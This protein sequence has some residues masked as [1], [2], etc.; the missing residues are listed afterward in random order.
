M[1]R[2]CFSAF[3]FLCLACGSFAKEV[4]SVSLPETVKV[5][6][7]TLKLNGMGL[8][9]QTLFHVKVYVLGL[10]LEDLCKDAAQV[11]S[12]EQIKRAQ[13]NFL[14]DVDHDKVNET[15]SKGFEKTAKDQLEALKPRIEKLLSLIPDLKE[16]DRLL[17]TYLPGKGTTVS[18]NG[19]E[20]GLI[21]GKDFASALFSIWI[22]RDPVDEGLKTALL[23][24]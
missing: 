22:G 4:A 10:Y 19:T 23:G 17:I 1:I 24:G 5:G 13:L 9:T 12:S 15:L 7:K 11:I 8:R 18:V 2:A 20:K 16:G 21:E 6:D 3:C 14:R